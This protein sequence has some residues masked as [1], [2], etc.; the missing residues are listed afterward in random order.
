MLA[1]TALALVAT[2]T[3]ADQVLAFNRAHRHAHLRRGDEVVQYDATETDVVTRYVTVTVP[4]DGEK[5]TP[6]ADAEDYNN[7]DN[8][9]PTTLLTYTRGPSTG[10][11]TRGGGRGGNRS[12]ATYSAPQPA[13]TTTTTAEEPVET[14]VEETP[15]EETPAE[16]PADETP[17]ETTAQPEIRQETTTPEVETESSGSGGKRGIAYNDAAAASTLLAAANSGKF[18]YSYNWDSNSNG[19]SS[20]L[21]YVPMLWGPIDVHTSRWNAN[22]DAMIAAG[23]TH[24]LSFNEC[25]NAGQCNMGAEA[26]A[27]AHVQWMNPYSGKAKIGSPAITNSNIPGE[28]LDWLRSFMKKCNEIDCAIDFCVTHWYDLPSATESLFDHISSVSEICG[29][30][31]VWVTEFAPVEASEQDIA[32][33]M[34]N[35]LSRL[36]SSSTVSAYFYFYT[37]VGS[38]LSDS[39]SLSSYGRLYATS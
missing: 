11:R 21:S 10:G 19:F 8:Q 23:S 16:T 1:K 32:N 24:L 33:F 3:L 6:D 34:P 20:S 13:A 7:D 12:S 4:A 29:G 39:G 25:D 35:V 17:T 9:S 37:A 18:G 26:A 27:A 2:M 30:K 36:D 31:K 15:A 38:L 22:A 28:G 14:P 5:T